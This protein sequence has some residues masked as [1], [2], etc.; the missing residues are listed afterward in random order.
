ME[1]Y[2]ISFS[3]R[4]LSLF[5]TKQDLI[6]GLLDKF[7][8]TYHSKRT[9]AIVRDYN[10]GILLLDI[11]RKSVDARHKPDIKIVYK[12]SF[13]DKKEYSTHLKEVNS[14]LERSVNVPDS[15]M[16]PIIIG[17][18]P[19]GLFATLVLAHNGYKPLIIE[20]GSKIEER[21][22][23]I[24]TIR[25]GGKVN[26]NSNIQF[27][28]GG[29]GTFSDGKLYSGVSSEYKEFILRK[30]NEHGASEEILY[31]SNPHIGTDVLRQVIVSI[32]KEIINCGGEFRFNTLLT[33]L[34]TE[35]NKVKGVKIF[36]LNKE[37]EEVIISDKV[38][39]AIGHSSRDTIRMLNSHG[40]EMNNKPFAVGVRIEHLREDIDISQYGFDTVDYDLLSAANYKLAVDTV[41]GK[42]LY[43][44]CMC[45]GGEVVASQSDSESICTNGMSYHARDLTN[46]NSALLIPVDEDDYG[47]NLLDGINYQEMLEHKAYIA[48]GSNGKAPI[49]TYKAL[50]EGTSEFTLGR[51][52]PSFKPGTGNCCFDMIFPPMFIETLKD[53]IHQMGKRIQG[54]DCDDAVLTAVEARSSSP[55][56]IVRDK[57]SLESVTIS[58][59][60]PAGEGAGY[61][62]G[63][64]SSAID[65]IRTAVK[66]VSNYS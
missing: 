1:T 55:V 50:C 28:E 30:F 54:F 29:A 65:G 31:D 37:R 8:S 10:Q 3:R 11:I 43:T 13:R 32:R 17:A 57:D 60:Y 23:D 22:R 26:N 66:I 6:N 49:M 21:V 42:K 52:K 62:G 48:G 12:F 27:G 4:E 9:A 5:H 24:D 56:R 39:L 14:I 19:C 53:G 59:L 47:H 35:N 38:I 45:P 64:M 16:R 34:L 36:D 7:K 2:E 51:I 25:S 41:T 15:A 58:G 46:S 20:R 40:I 63:I 18:G 33:D 44:F 61:A